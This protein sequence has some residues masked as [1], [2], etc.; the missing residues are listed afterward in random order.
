MG[1][2]ITIGPGGKTSKKV[3]KYFSDFKKIYRA[4]NRIPNPGTYSFNDEETKKINDFLDKVGVR[5][6]GSITAKFVDQEDS[7]DAQ[8]A[9]DRKAIKARR[10]ALKTLQG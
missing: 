2:Q 10:S 3:D 8:R 1:T 4:Q 7:Q 5:K 9:Y 6:N